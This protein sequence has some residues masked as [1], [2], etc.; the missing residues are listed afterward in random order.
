MALG[1]WSSSMYVERGMPVLT[2]VLGMELVWNQGIKSLDGV[3][4][5][6]SVLEGLFPN[7]K[8]TTIQSHE[9]HFYF[10]NTSPL[11]RI[12]SIDGY[13]FYTHI[14]SVETILCFGM[15]G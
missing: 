12:A 3:H 13:R 10:K 8:F 2:G 6:N 14:R 9:C 4:R 11:Q 1:S 5:K 15:E 7:H